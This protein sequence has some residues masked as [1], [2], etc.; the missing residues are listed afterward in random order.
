MYMFIPVPKP[1]IY[2]KKLI[3]LIVILYQIYQIFRGASYS[4]ALAYCAILYVTYMLPNMSLDLYWSV[5]Y[6]IS[7]EFAKY[8]N[9]CLSVQIDVCMSVCKFKVMLK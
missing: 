4:M 5:E 7:Y 8:T 6:S 2:S 3:C 1:Y 9:L